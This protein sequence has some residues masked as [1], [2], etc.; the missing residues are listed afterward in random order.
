MA[1]SKHGGEGGG[2]RMVLLRIH[3]KN[4]EEG[5]SRDIIIGSGGRDVLP[6]STIGKEGGG[7]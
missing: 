4:E 5:R 7:R 1:R 3:R 6:L 2:N